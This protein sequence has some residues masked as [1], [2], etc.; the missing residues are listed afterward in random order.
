MKWLYNFLN[1]LL[2]SVL[3][4]VVLLIIMKNNTS[5]ANKFYLQVYDNNFSFAK[6]NNWYQNHFKSELPF[7]KYFKDK[8]QTVFNEKLKYFSKKKYQDGVLLT[9]DD[10]YLVPVIKEGMVIF[11]GNKDNLGNTVIIE[12]KNGLEIWY[13][14]IANMNV[15]L[16]DY[17][18]KGSLIGE[19]KGNK[20]YLI[21]KKD[22][23]V[24]DYKKYF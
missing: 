18:K 6:V 10:N 5:F 8:N 13:S 1:R 3:L 20:L 14:N 17:V 24:L 11:A 7:Y 4:M 2:I 19:L 15:S 23:Q 9:V 21:Y 16:Y 22:G 12:D